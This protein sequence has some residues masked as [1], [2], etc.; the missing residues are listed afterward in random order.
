M[1]VKKGIYRHHKGR[2]YEVLHTARHSETEEEHVVYRALYG[3]YGI[4]IRTLQMF[5]ETIEKDGQR[6]KRF[7]LVEEK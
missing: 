7:S 5:D 4:W 3:D 1:S 2:L 6:I